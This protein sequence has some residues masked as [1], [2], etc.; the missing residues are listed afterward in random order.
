MNNVAHMAWLDGVITSLSCTVGKHVQTNHI[1]LHE[2]SGNSV[3]YFGYGAVGLAYLKRESDHF[4]YIEIN[5]RQTRFW[6][7][8]RR[9]SLMD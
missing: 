7:D 1:Q 4:H 8:G 2:L 5:A 3:G 6:R 9:L